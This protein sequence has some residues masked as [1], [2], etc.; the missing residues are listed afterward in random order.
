MVWYEAPA[1]EV[2][3]GLFPEVALLLAAAEEEPEA[4]AL[5][6]EEWEAPLVMA[7]EPETEAVEDAAALPVIVVPA[8]VV[9]R[10]GT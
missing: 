10:P 7:P 4:P 3:Q 6:V 8:S 1:E 5:E 9:V 2:L